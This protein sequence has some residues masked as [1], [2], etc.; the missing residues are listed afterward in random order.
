M[1]PF[2]TLLVKTHWLSKNHVIILEPHLNTGEMRRILTG[3]PRVTWSKESL[4]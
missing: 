3:P 2:L 1:V 4:Q